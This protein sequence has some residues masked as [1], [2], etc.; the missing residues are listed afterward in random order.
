V[1]ATLGVFLVD[2]HTFAAINPDRTHYR[3]AGSCGGAAYCGYRTNKK[4]KAPNPHSSESI[5]LGG[6][7]PV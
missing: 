5:T 3:G 1:A 6:V 2:I 7:L 4:V